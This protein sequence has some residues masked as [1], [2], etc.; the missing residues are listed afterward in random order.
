M[1]VSGKV[2]STEIRDRGM[3]AVVRCNG[4][5]PKPGTQVSV[6]WGRSRSTG[7]NAIY[8]VWINWVYENG[9]KEEGYSSPEE[10]HEAFKGRFLTVMK[11]GP[12]GMKS[13]HIKS[14]TELD[15]QEFTEYMDKCQV[16][17][18]EFLRIDDAEF[19]KEYQD[20]H[21]NIGG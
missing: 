3:F 8:W 16:A 14:T 20:F 15:T 7:Q 13:Y 19:W 5:L 18:K 4:K 10:L 11:S 12:N 17:V 1:K 21:A 6:K 2:I 9:A